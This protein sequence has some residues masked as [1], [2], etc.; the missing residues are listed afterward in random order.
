LQRHGRCD[1][2]RITP[3]PII[4]GPV[5]QGVAKNAA[6]RFEWRVVAEASQHSQHSC[7]SCCVI[8]QNVQG[9][10]QVGINESTQRDVSQTGSQTGDVT[11]T[12]SLTSTSWKST[13]HLEE[14][15]HT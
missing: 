13:K 4:F 9:D 5:A 2:D 8:N 6:V 14:K 7:H 15:R 3:S 11:Q 10:G 1:H 12:G